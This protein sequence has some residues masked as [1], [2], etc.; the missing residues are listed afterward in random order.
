MVTKIAERQIIKGPY[1]L[2]EDIIGTPSTCTFTFI[3]NPANGDSWTGF[4]DGDYF[5]FN[6]SN[7]GDNVSDVLIGATKELTLNNLVTFFSNNGIVGFT[8][9]SSTTLLWSSDPA[10]GTS[11]NAGMG[12]LPSAITASDNPSV[13]TDGTDQTIAAR[14]TYPDLALK[15]DASKYLNPIGKP[16]LQQRNNTTTLAIDGALQRSVKSGVSYIFKVIIAVG[17]GTTG[18]IKVAMNGPT[19]ANFRSFTKILNQST[20]AI[21]AYLNTTAPGTATSAAGLGGYDIEIEGFF[22]PSADGTFG[23]YWAQNVSNAT[24]T[25]V[26]NQS[27]MDVRPC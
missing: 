17:C 18:G 4:H 23:L 5:D 25:G 14:A 6:F 27:F 21:V 8:K 1:A 12:A 11:A 10:L 2:L 16:S 3:S 20:G 22:T 15:L 26:G 24:N 19:M 13:A 9:T 7:T